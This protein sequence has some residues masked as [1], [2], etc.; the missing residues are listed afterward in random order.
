[1]TRLLRAIWILGCGT[2]IQRRN[3]ELPQ[4][5]FKINREKWPSFIDADP[6]VK[7]Q[8]IN[9]NRMYFGK[10]RHS[11]SEPFYKIHKLHSAPT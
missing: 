6:E 8:M 2:G 7:I 4:N 5:F 11:I 3:K 1:M 9:V 10:E